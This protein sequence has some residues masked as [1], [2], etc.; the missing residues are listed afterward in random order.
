MDNLP[1]ITVTDLYNDNKLKFFRGRYNILDCGVRTGK[2]YWAV[3]NL[4]DF[5]RDGQARRILF[6]VDTLAL[7]DS[8]LTQYCDN[9]CDADIMWQRDENSWSV[10]DYNKIGVMC[11]QTLGMQVIRDDVAFLD[12]IDV[13]CWDECDSIFDFAATAFARARKTDFSRKNSTNA[14]IL[15]LIQQHSTKKDYMPLILLG[16]W[17][18]LIYGNRILCIGL[19]ATPQRAQEY[20]NSLTH[21]SY[22]G[23][24]QTSYR[25]TAD[26][27]FKNII[28]HINELTPVPGVGYWCFSP[29]IQHNCNIVNAARNRGFSAI[30]LHSPNNP[31]VPLTEEQKNVIE[32]IDKLHVVPYGYDFIVITRA[33]E[34]GIDIIDPRFR[35][36]IVDSYYQTDRIQAARQTFPYQRHVKV[37]S[38]E[39]PNDYLNRWLTLQECRELAEVMSVPDVDIKNTSGGRIQSRPMSWNKLQSVL[40]TLGYEVEKKRKRINGSTNPLNCYMIT[41][42]WHDVEIVADHNFMDLVAAKT[43][44]ELNEMDDE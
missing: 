9:C 3:N 38:G 22:T 39:V 15:S 26:I 13:I 37:F 29:S 33:F 20:Y 17:E 25:A 1:A 18:Q 27:Y 30:E 32:C 44:T 43:N 31:D 14:E 11:Y 21:E 8:I 34:R 41:G 5:T 36:L 23:K 16:F 28:D 19:S 2:T 6:L 40:P 24:I 7:K 12:S 4:K 42:E 35:H 10:E